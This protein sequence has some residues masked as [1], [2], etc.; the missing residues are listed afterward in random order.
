M[1]FNPAFNK[2]P[3]LVNTLQEELILQS[4]KVTILLLY[5]QK[6]V[7][8]IIDAFKTPDLVATI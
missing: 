8:I 7:K 2:E 3:E 5:T 1:D 6:G 4:K